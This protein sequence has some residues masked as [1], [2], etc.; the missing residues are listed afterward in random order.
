MDHSLEAYY[1]NELIFFSDKK[2]LYPLLDLESFLQATPYSLSQILIKDKIIGKAAALILVYFKIRFVE[3]EIISRLGL[4]TLTDFKVTFT[5]QKLVD[6]VY[7][8]TEKILQHENNPHQGYQLIKDRI[9][10][11][12]TGKKSDH[13]R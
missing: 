8:E 10:Q 7:C 9:E 4:Q 5:Y 3:A 6:R 12:K 1:Q 11:N 2:W 13:H